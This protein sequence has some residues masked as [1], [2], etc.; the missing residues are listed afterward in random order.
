M[1]TTKC[2]AKEFRKFAHSR[3]R[4]PVPSQDPHRPFPTHT[5]VFKILQRSTDGQRF[6]RLGRGGPRVARP[7]VPPC[8]CRIIC[9][10]CRGPSPYLRRTFAVPP[11]VHPRISLRNPNMKRPWY[12]VGTAQVRRRCGVES[13]QTMRSVALK[14]LRRICHQRWLEAFWVLRLSGGALTIIGGRGDATFRAILVGLV[15]G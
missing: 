3:R 6:C 7:Q 9:A 1:Q 13:L 14:R 12:G 8:P 5:H 2:P 10:V 4:I 11:L 15:G